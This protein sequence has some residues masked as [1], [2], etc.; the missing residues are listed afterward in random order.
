[1]FLQSLQSA[2]DSVQINED[3]I[4]RDLLLGGRGL[5]LR[6]PSLDALEQGI[7]LLFGYSP[8][9][10]RNLDEENGTQQKR[11]KSGH[12]PVAKISPKWRKVKNYAGLGRC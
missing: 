5:L 7:H 12:F 11:K 4:L 2:L 3:Q 8:C 9:M 1:M 10:K 6:C